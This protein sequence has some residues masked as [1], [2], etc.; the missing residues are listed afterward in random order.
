MRVNIVLLLHE[1]GILNILSFIVTARIIKRK[2]AGNAKLSKSALMGEC[3]N[4]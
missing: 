1:E 2:S 3:S 4:N